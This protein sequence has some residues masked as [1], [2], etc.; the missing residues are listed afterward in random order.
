MQHTY[1][2][3]HTTYIVCGYKIVNLKALQSNV[4]KPEETDGL[5]V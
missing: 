3:S 1:M 2:H 4:Y 5:L